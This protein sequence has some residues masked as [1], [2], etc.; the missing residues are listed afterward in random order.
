MLKLSLDLTVW[1]A[2]G[3]TFKERFC[4]NLGVNEA[5]HELMYVALSRDAK[6]SKTA[7]VSVITGTS[8]RSLN[9]NAKIAPR[10]EHNVDL[11]RRSILTK[12]RLLRV[13][14]NT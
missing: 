8:T 10:V 9:K 4:I 14:E 7:I 12:E 1:K 13:S 5:E 6:L 11:L 3:S 2:H